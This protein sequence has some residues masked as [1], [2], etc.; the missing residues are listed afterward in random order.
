MFP[1]QTQL[2]SKTF[3]IRPNCAPIVYDQTQVRSPALPI[4]PNCAR[5]VYDKT[6]VRSN[7]PFDETFQTN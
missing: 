5:T 6:K 2:R 4:R 3:L 7:T 1:V